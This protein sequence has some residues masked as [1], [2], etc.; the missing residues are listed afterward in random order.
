MGA[1]IL[2]QRLAFFVVVVDR[3]AYQIVVSLHI[4]VEAL[5]ALC[6]VDGLDLFIAVGIE[7]TVDLLLHARL[8]ILPIRRLAPGH[9]P[10]SVLHEDTDGVACNAV[11]LIFGIARIGEESAVAERGRE[12]VQDGSPAPVRS[13]L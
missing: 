1:P 7:N 4:G 2:L 12:G 9:A 11:E 13:S 10:P 6:L 3:L 5:P 8:R